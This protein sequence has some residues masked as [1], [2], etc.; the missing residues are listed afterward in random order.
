MEEK[1][2]IIF[3]LERINPK[4][5]LSS[6]RIMKRQVLQ[7]KD[8]FEKICTVFDDT[9]E[10]VIEFR[11]CSKCLVKHKE[12]VP[13]DPYLQM[14]FIKADKATIDN[15][16]HVLRPHVKHRMEKIPPRAFLGI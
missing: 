4:A 2:G 1:W 8:E 11:W 10:G 5:F 7:C 3:G 15:L 6:Q 14:C 12:D 16:F 9:P 13:N